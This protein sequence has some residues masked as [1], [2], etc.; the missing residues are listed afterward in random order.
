MSPFFVFF[1]IVTVIYVM[2]YGIMFALDVTAKPKTAASN[3]E[4]FEGESNYEESP[5]AP[6]E[7]LEEDERPYIFS[8]EPL[9][10]EENG[11]SESE[12]V[13]PIPNDNIVVA[14]PS[15]DNAQNDY[16]M[17]DAEQA[18]S[19]S[20]AEESPSIQESLEEEPSPS[21]YPSSE[22]VKDAD[23]VSPQEAAVSP[24][25]N[26]A[27]SPDEGSNVSSNFFWGDE[28]LSLTQIVDELN[29]SFE[30]TAVRYVG[31]MT[32]EELK[33]S[34]EKPDSEIDSKTTVDRL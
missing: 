5:S 12:T 10:D 1:L 26:V 30:S 31:E 29:E 18:Y 27:L 22:S 11:S 13:N 8:E 15:A 3:V 17:S 34:I 19:F 24:D 23:V 14:P 33:T 2:Y 6:L 16:V 9:P 32:L 25:T 7:P 21:S 4:F 28:P 20:N